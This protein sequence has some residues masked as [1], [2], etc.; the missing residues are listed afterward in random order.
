MSSQQAV[1]DLM[2]QIG[3]VLELAQVTEFADDASWRL[4]FDADTQMDIEYDPQ[5]ERLMI[6]GNLAAEPQNREKAFEALLRYNYLWTA[7]GGVRAAL[8]GVPGKLV[9]MLEMPTARL[10]M[11]H[12][13]A[14]LQNF[15]TVIDGWRAILKGNTSTQAADELP[16]DWTGIIRC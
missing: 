15:R 10:E 16:V 5:G 9:L 12:L 7:H 6:T 4:V 8:D 11:S 13:C 1:H 3:P 2:A 14:V